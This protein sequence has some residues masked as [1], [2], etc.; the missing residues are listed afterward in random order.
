MN[1]FYPGTDFQKQC[2][3]KIREKLSSPKPADREWKKEVL[4]RHEQG[5]NVTPAALDLAR[6]GM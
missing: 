6:R 3:E 5:G 1:R 4:A 2:W